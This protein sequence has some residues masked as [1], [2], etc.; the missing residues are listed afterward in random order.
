MSRIGKKIITLPSGV[1][2]TSKG[3]NLLIEGKLGK[4]ELPLLPGISYTLED[5]VLSFARAN[6]TQQFRQNHGTMRALVNNAVNGV[7]T[8]FV[9]QLELRGTGY[10][11]AIRG[12]DI[13]L[14]VGFS[15]EVV[16][17]PLPGVT[18]EC[19]K[20]TEIT[21]KGIN[22]EHVFETAARIRGIKPPE[23]YQGKGIRY[24]GEYVPHK[25]GKRTGKK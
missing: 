24:L 5:S 23:P 7:T 9:K 12:S 13:V 4:I 22:K 2:V 25:E 18:I 11:S 17:S 16:V 19:P 14:S 8:G 1:S 20:Q 21:V 6:D 10:R 15:H 3:P